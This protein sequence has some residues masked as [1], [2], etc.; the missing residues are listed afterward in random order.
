VTPRLG[1][2]ANAAQFTLLVIV[3]AFVGAMVGLERTVLPAIATNEFHLA[4]RAAILSF[5][6]AFGVSKALTNYAAGRL[7]DRFGRKHVLVAGWMVAVPVPFMLM[8]APSWNGILAANLLLGISQGLTWSTTV[9]MKIDL[10]GAERRGLAMGLNE[11]AG[12]LALAGS[13]LATGWIAAHSHLRPEPFYLGIG[14]VGV[15]L[16]LSAFL[17]RDTRGHVI[18]ESRGMP[19]RTTVTA[20]EVFWRTSVTD[21]SLSSASQAGLVNNLN[22]GMGPVSAVLR[23]RADPAGANRLAGCDVSRDMGRGATRHWRALGPDRPQM[24][25]CGRHVDTG[26]GDRL[27]RHVAHVSGIRGRPVRARPRHGDG[28]SDTACRRR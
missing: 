2:R 4:A 11:F 15:G 22:D 10:M 5:I 3:N 8:W 13:A 25:D 21:P 23:R 28:V 17:V 24:V 26:G 19:D 27:H 16:F 20:P 12:Y 18:L 14:F 1:L 9:I 6:V 7:S